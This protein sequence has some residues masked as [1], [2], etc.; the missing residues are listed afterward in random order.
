MEFIRKHHLV[1][2][3]LSLLVAI[4]LWVVVI[5]ADNPKKTLE[6]QNLPVELLEQD[7][8]RANHGLVVSKID[9]E[10]VSV[11]VAGNFKTLS[12]VSAENIKVRADL[13]DYTEP[14][15]YRLS[16]DVSV[17]IG[18][19]VESR[20]PERIPIVLEEIVDKELPVQVVYEGVL[21]TG[22][23][24]SG[25]TVEPSTVR[26]SGIA[27]VMEKADHALVTVNVAGLTEDYSA[28]HDY[29]IADSE[30]NTIQ[31]PYTSFI[32]KSVNV[33]IPVYMT[34]TVPVEVSVIGSAGV[35]RTSVAVVYE[36]AEVTVYGRAADVRSLRSFNVGEI[37]V[38]DFVLTCNRTFPLT[39]PENVDFYDD[40]VEDV[41]VYVYFRDVETTVIPISN[42]VLEN[43]P[44]GMDVEL[45]TTSLDVTVR[46]AAD[47]LKKLNADNIRATV[48]LSGI[49]TS[50][51]RRVLP[52]DVKIGIGGYDVCGTY[53]VTVSV[54]E[55]PGEEE[56][57]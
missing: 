52:A 41:D 14:G 31:A 39:L 32:D 44:D 46:S 40:V 18:I 23:S 28:S 25:V 15:T 2:K 38:R 37:N 21:P 55:P 56:E 13:S 42:I 22:I 1:M 9:T 5:N 8:L 6:F 47:M 34:R 57:P 33:E 29:V 48:D 11:K 36:P 24:F 7:T 51:P 3:L 16:Y 26:V 20:S 50:S 53:T 54:S 19:T 49:D 27:S 4:S 43:V 12:N 30:D 45:M 17:P 35:A 10:A